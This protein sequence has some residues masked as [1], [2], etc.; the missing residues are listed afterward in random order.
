MGNFKLRPRQKL[1]KTTKVRV[2]EANTLSLI[3]KVL[4]S[5][6]ELKTFTF[7]GNDKE[8]I[9]FGNTTLS[10][11]DYNV[12]KL[13]PGAFV[14]SELQQGVEQGQRIGNSINIKKV[15]LNLIIVPKNYDSAT[16]PSPEPLN[17]RVIIL[18][19]KQNPQEVI[20]A[21]TFFQDGNSTQSPVSNLRDMMQDINKD[22]FVKSRDFRRKIGH[23]IAN[24]NGQ[25]AV[26]QNYANNDYKFNSIDKL[27]I[28]KA[29][30]RKMRWDDDIAVPISFNP[31]MVFLFSGADGGTNAASTIPLEFTYQVTI[32]YT[33]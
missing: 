17:V 6:D 27:D 31:Y 32:H 18:H 33:D 22:M 25:V 10:F 20:V 7:N 15:M 5:K 29:F 1:K 4:S 14:T 28:T 2:R 9:D 19:S 23:A 13:A 24:E 11:N 12:I 26:Q 16:N 3:K 30:P 21:D 8:L